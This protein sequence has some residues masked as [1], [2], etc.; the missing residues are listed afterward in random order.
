MVNASRSLS[1]SLASD[2]YSGSLTTPPCTEQ[3]DWLVVQTPILASN[4]QIGA[5]QKTMC[6]NNRATP[7][8]DGRTF[9]ASR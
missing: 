2:R 7:P 8:L 6:G 4:E 5:M 3:V 9:T 1:A